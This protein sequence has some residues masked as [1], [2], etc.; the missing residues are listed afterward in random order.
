MQLP[1]ISLT[2]NFRETCFFQ[3]VACYLDQKPWLE[4]Q[5]RPW[6]NSIITDMWTL[7]KS[8]TDFDNFFVPQELPFFGYRT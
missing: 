7:E 8:K 2:S 4:R 5:L 1:K 3:L 6:G